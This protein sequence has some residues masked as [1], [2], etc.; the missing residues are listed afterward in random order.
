LPYQSQSNGLIDTAMKTAKMLQKKALWSH[1]DKWTNRGHGK[2]PSAE[3]DVQEN[4]NHHSNCTTSATARSTATCEYE[5]S[6]K[7]RKSKEIL[8][9]RPRYQRPARVWHWSTY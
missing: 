5:V 7:A 6:K 3:V 1:H 9:I 2:Q 8:A 4:Q